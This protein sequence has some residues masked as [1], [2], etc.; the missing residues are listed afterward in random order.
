MQAR[1]LRIL[2][3]HAYF[4]HASEQWLF[5]GLSWGPG[6]LEGEAFM[7]TPDGAGFLQ[8]PTV[9]ET[10]LERTAEKRGRSAAG[11]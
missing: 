4:E 1:M 3:G 10:R 6:H 9:H 7:L 8:I 2:K 5:F 11:R